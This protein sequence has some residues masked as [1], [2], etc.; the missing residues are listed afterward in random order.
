MIGVLLVNVKIIN[1]VN[2][3]YMLYLS[4]GVK[5][6]NGKNTYSVVKV[7]SIFMTVP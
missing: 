3:H 4:L 1:A 2:F 7:F 6:E 5:F